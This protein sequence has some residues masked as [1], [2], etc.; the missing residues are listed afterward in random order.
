[1]ATRWGLEVV[2]GMLDDVITMRQFEYFTTT[3][4]L[5]PRE[6]ILDELLH[7]LRAIDNVADEGVGFGIRLPL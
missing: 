2:D 3:H 7:V 1:M 6:W 5:G 4:H